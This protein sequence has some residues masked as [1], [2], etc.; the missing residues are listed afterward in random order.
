MKIYVTGF[1]ESAEYKEAVK[2]RKPVSAEDSHDISYNV[3]PYWTFPEKK[4]AESELRILQQ[5]RIHMGNHYCQLE[6]EQVGEEK[7]AMFC[8]DHPEP[9]RLSK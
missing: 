6:V 9:N 7:Y 8:N 4:L 5:I 1:K 2:S 3:E